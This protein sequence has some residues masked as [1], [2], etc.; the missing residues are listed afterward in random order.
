[1]LNNRVLRKIFGPRRKKLTQE[2]RRRHNEKLHNLYSSYT[3]ISV[4]KSRRMKWVKHV[5][6]WGMADVHTGL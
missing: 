3:I 6:L 4:I 1:M 5:A 2:W